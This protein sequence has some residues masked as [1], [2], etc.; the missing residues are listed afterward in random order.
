MKRVI[1]VVVLITLILIA[2]FL[3]AKPG[4]KGNLTPPQ[5]NIPQTASPSVTEELPPTAE[6]QEALMEAS[7][8]LAQSETASGQLTEKVNVVEYRLNGSVEWNNAELNQKFMNGDTLRTGADS[9][10]QLAFSD[11][12]TVRLNG[13][14]Q[15]TI[16][17]VDKEINLSLGKIF[18]S[19]FKGT[20]SPKVVT[21]NA[22]AAA[23]GTMWVQEQKEDGTSEINVLEGQVNFT[24][25][26]VSEVV[27][28][29]NFTKALHKKPPIKPQKFNI[30]NYAQSERIL[31]KVK[32]KKLAE[33][34]KKH[35]ETFYKKLD[36]H[37]ELKQKIEQKMQQLK[38]EKKELIEK[39]LED[40]KEIKPQVKEKIEEK[41]AI[42]K[43]IIEKKLDEK[44]ELK[45]QIKE[46]I[47]EKKLQQNENIKKQLEEKKVDNIEKKKE[48]IQE[49]KQEYIDK[50]QQLQKEDN[51]KAYELKKKVVEEK[52]SQMQEEN[53]KNI[54]ENK[55]EQF[56]QNPEK[57]KL[58]EEKRFTPNQPIKQ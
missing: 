44:K 7:S 4:N 49:K 17:P 10:A 48:L 18:V 36:E 41:K 15:I 11:G 35:D 23:L 58:F 45:P 52:K 26:G 50:K 40:K 56:H 55:K 46:K 3:A 32:L 14:T 2:M 24:S 38:V 57:K 47:E 51:L 19:F 12:S 1:I 9:E 21:P 6:Q 37:P 29:G 25:E 20:S 42:K 27:D 53:K 33:L 8:T 16:N 13:L 30:D 5:T 43:E 31:K 39:K 34:H 54:L 22:V 28:E